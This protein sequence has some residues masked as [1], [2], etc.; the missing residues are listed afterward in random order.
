MHAP[1]QASHPVFSVAEVVFFAILLIAGGLL[2]YLDHQW[3]MGTILLEYVHAAIITLV[4]ISCVVAQLKFP[5]IKRYGWSQI[6]VGILLLMIAAWADILDNFD[7]TILGIPF[8]HSWQQAYIEKIMGYTVG[9]SLIAVGFSRW[10]P[11]MIETRRRVEVLNRELTS[12]ITNFDE[13]VES[14][15]LTISRE[16]HDD[17]AQQ[18][19]Y[20]TFQTQILET[21]AN[22]SDA[23]KPALQQFGSEVSETLKTV[24]RISQNLRPESLF[25]LGFHDALRQFIDKQRVQAPA[26][27]ITYTLVPIAE[28]VEARRLEE[29]F[30]EENLLHVFRLV[31]ES[32]RNAIKHSQGHYIDAMFRE[33]DDAFVFTVSDDGQGLKWAT[34]P[35][36]DELVEQGHLGIAGMRERAAALNGTYTIENRYNERHQ[37]LGSIVTIRIPK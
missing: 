2:A 6:F 28:G 23:L 8:G 14:E 4:F 25:A 5:E 12:L 22:D 29:H 15:R 27:T 21:K 11:W 24:R 31:Q 16:L 32:V 1:N 18:L 13:R 10:I 37:I 7:V 33:E 26:Y 30:D 34:A 3:Q 35:G 19:T 9:V 36:N 20:L 17:V